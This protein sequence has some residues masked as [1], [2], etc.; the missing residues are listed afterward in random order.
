M[1]K[2]GQLARLA[3][4]CI[5]LRPYYKEVKKKGGQPATP[6]HVTHTLTWY[7]LTSGPE[8]LNKC[9]DEM[10]KNSRALNCCRY[11]EPEI[12]LLHILHIHKTMTS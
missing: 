6:M 3:S 11:N 5:N 7:S 12:K 8:K 2:A 10:S 1:V 4:L 9:R